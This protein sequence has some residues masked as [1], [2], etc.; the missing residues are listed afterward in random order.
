M[1]WKKEYEV[2]SSKGYASGHMWDTE[3][4]PSSNQQNAANWKVPYAWYFV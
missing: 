3:T 2:R 1:F 4:L